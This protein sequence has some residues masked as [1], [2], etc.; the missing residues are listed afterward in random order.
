MRSF[1]AVGLTETTRQACTALITRLRLQP[2]FEDARVTWAKP[3]NLHITLQF[4]GD[5]EGARGAQVLSSLTAPWPM[6]LFDITLGGCGV[7][8]SRGTPR[9]VYVDLG[10]G[11]DRLSELQIEVARR[12]RT[13][14][15]VVK[16]QR[17]RPHVT[18][19][20]VRR[21]TPDVGSRIRT[22]VASV[23]DDI[24]DSSID[25]V[26]LYES[27]LLPGGPLHEP[28][29]RVQLGAVG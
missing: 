19:A 4:L 13:C 20:R 3:E 15:F 16:S 18:I 1:V 2:V 9:A 27:R 11:V 6:D 22:V 14:G 25:H 21:G 5:L 29:L 17:F 10:V 28:V 26:V 7:F 24:S 8:P 12:L 23:A